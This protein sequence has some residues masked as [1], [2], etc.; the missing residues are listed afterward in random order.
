MGRPL[1]KRRIIPVELL[2]DGRLVKSSR[3]DTFR[4][5][6]D[7]LKSSQVY[8][9]QD[10]D[11]LVLLNVERDRRDPLAV[12]PILQKIA[13]TCFMPIAAG[14]GLVTIADAAALF[15]AGADKVIINSAAYTDKALLSEIAHRYG[16]QALVVSIDV[17]LGA[18]GYEL[19]S[20]CGRRKQSIGLD[21][22]LRQVIDAGAGEILLNA[23]DRDGVMQGYDLALLAHVRTICSVPLIICGG[24]GN[25]N[26]LLEAFELG[27]DATAC[28]S[29]FNFGDNNPLRV[30]AF[31]KN[32]NVPLKKI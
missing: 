4:D 29:L 24:A 7:P 23:I 19:Y 28:G 30:K 17:A 27:A 18:A 6:G 8:A 5:V 32:H 20:N 31:L 14:G 10:A 11:E 13:E 3:F 26:H 25:Y 1:L 16:S 12:V 15:T 21:D 2:M 9:N 22:H